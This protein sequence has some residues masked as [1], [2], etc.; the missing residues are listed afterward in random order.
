MKPNIAVE[1]TYLNRVPSTLNM[2]RRAAIILARIIHEC[3]A[4]RQIELF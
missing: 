2:I 3:L 1:L 4:G